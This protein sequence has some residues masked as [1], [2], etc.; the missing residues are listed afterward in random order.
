MREVMSGKRNSIC[1]ILFAEHPSL[2][3]QPLTNGVLKN[4]GLFFSDENWV[5]WDLTQ[6]QR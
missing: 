5:T 2:D 4:L 3:R 6:Y 1:H